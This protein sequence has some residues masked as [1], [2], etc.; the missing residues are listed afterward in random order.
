[1]EKDQP[2]KINFVS[3][4]EILWNDRTS[5]LKIRVNILINIDI[6]I[7]LFFQADFLKKKIV[8]WVFTLVSFP[9]RVWFYIIICYTFCYY[10]ETVCVR[11][12]RLQSGAW[13]SKISGSRSETRPGQRRQIDGV[14]RCVMDASGL[15]RRWQHL[16][17]Y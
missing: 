4:L 16:G 14:A 2:K 3:F 13:S 1:M 15:I 11:G 12:I 6:L 9:F 7:F 17:A 8:H 10:D 5:V